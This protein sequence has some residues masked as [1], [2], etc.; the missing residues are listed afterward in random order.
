MR[1][2]KPKTS[3]APDGTEQDLDHRF[4]LSTCKTRYI[5]MPFGSIWSFLHVFAWKNLGLV[6]LLYTTDIPFVS[7][8]EFISV[9]ISP[10]TRSMT[11]KPYQN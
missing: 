3:I 1:H 10:A 6:A 9:S 11:P 2:R 7:K 8:D 5:N 4:S